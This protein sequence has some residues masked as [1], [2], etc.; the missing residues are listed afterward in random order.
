MLVAALFCVGVSQVISSSLKDTVA[1]T[2][3]ESNWCK[4]RS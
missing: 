2:Q 4:G 3:N 1:K